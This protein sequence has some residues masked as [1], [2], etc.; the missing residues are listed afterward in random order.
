MWLSRASFLTKKN[1]HNFNFV[2]CKKY[3]CFIHYLYFNI[4]SI[5]NHNK[6]KTKHVIIIIYSV[7]DI[8]L[9]YFPLH[10]CNTIAVTNSVL[11]TIV[12]V[13]FIVNKNSIYRKHQKHQ[14]TLPNF[15]LITSDVDY[16]ICALWCVQLPLKSHDLKHN[17]HIL[18]YIMFAIL[19][20]RRCHT[21]ETLL[22]FLVLLNCY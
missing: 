11:Y 2:N 15:V 20:V 18:L 4:K 1:R 13:I 19:Y 9:I 7:F 8:I 16:F 5:D 12:N 21:V 6:K 14:R 22:L 3:L 17:T 10:F